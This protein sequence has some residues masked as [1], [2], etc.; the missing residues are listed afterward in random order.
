MIGRMQHLE[1][2]DDDPNIDTWAKSGR[3]PG[4]GEPKVN[5]PENLAWLRERVLRGDR[6]GIAR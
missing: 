4:P 6:F 3:M 2:F 1:R 5:W